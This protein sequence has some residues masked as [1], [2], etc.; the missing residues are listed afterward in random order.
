MAANDECEDLEREKMIQDL[1]P[2]PVKVSEPSYHWADGKVR[3]ERSCK[4]CGSYPADVAREAFART[5]GVCIS[6]VESDYN[7]GMYTL[8]NYEIVVS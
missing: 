5:L 2:L 1:L 7:F 6:T 8:R 3:V 4:V